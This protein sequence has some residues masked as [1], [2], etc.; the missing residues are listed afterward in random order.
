M[1]RGNL[2]YELVM[3]SYYHIFKD[4]KNVRNQVGRIE[5]LGREGI[6]AAALVASA[7]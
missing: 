7:A 1:F 4:S 3:F 5:G 6:N 2:L